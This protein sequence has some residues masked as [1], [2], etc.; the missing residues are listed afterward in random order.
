MDTNSGDEPDPF[1]EADYFTVETPLQ[2]TLDHLGSVRVFDY[3]LCLPLDPSA[4][5]CNTGSADLLGYI[6]SLHLASFANAT[7]GA[8]L[9]SSTGSSLDPTNPAPAPGSLLLAALGFFGIWIGRR[10]R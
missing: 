10:N 2:G 5:D 4:P 3:S 7:G 9:N 6:G 8:F 1:V